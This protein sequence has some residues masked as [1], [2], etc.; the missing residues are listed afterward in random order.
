MG[1]VGI[2]KEMDMQLWYRRA[3][4]M[5]QFF[6]DADYHRERVAQLMDL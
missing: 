3:K 4:A 1:G 6:G 2:Y 5:E